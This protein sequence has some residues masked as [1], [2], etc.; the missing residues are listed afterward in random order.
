MPGGPRGRVCVS[1][2]SSSRQM[3]GLQRGGGGGHLLTGPH[4]L[5][6]ETAQLAGLLVGV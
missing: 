3:A 4:G 2:V 6:P 5:W 1:K